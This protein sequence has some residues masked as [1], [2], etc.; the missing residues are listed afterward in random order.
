MSTLFEGS[1]LGDG[2]RLSGDARLECGICWTVYDP[3][4]GD[5][6]WQVPPGTA[7][8]DLPGHW[9][10][11]TCDAER[12]KFMVL[13]GASRECGEPAVDDAD[14]PASGARLP[15]DLRTTLLA[16]YQEAGE[17]MR[18]LPVYNAY[19]DVAVLEP[20]DH[21][22]AKVTLVATPWFL[23]I[24]RVGDPSTPA[25]GAERELA[26]PSGNYRFVAGVLDG[27]GP[28]ESC[29]LISPMEDFTAM[30]Q[31]LTLAEETLEAL[32]TSPVELEA[33]APPRE[34]SRRRFMGAQETVG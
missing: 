5:P 3:A 22:G 33:A 21:D 12:H 30:E 23:N 27:V 34:V 1:Y 25:P 9:R 15:V 31:V 28:I 11:P 17:R 20:R 26:F 16:A 6:V 10:C 13:D 19:L 24:L 2:A 18:D 7:F 29:S 32:F 8:A 14:D 4:V